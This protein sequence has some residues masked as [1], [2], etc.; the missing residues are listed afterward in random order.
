MDIDAI[1]DG[2]RR[3]EDGIWYSKE[4]SEVSYPEDA[5]SLCAEL[6]ED[7]FWFR[8]RNRC[9]ASVVERYRPDGA[10][11]DIGGGNGFVSKGLQEAGHEVVLLEPSLEGVLRAQKR[12]IEQ[13]ICATF[14]DASFREESMAA[15]GMFD[16]VEHIEDDLGL[17]RAL[18]PLIKKGGFVFVTVPAYELLWSDHDDEAGHFRRYTRASMTGLL[19]SAGFEVKHATYFF[20]LLPLPIFLLRALPA[21]LGLGKAGSK[22]HTKKEHTSE[23]IAQTLLSKLWDKE[24][25]MIKRGRALPVGGSLLMVAQRVR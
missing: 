1:S 8:H 17:L 22:E 19:T 21:R 23:G 3:H 2:L 5:T 10:I 18:R 4:V 13:L 25:A 6:E 15:V 16:V 24:Y 9:I 11:F 14:Q 12:G 20:S 7:S